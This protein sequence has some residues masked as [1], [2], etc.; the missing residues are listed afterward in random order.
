MRSGK[1]R[2]SKQRSQ[3]GDWHKFPI[4]FYEYGMWFRSSYRS[5]Y[6]RTVLR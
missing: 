3:Q 6:D 2:L 4:V 1:H 5:T